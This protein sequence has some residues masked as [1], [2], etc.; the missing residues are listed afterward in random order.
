MMSKLRKKVARFER[1]RNR[2][3]SLYKTTSDRL[4]LCVYRSNKNIEAQIIDDS[5]GVT[6]ASASTVDKVIK[7]KII[8]TLSKKE[9]SKLVG[10]TLAERAIKKKVKLVVFDRNG[11]SYQGRVK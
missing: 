7:S 3:K 6:I 10:K 8:N 11:F 5:K 4:R 1:R 9:Q 2:S